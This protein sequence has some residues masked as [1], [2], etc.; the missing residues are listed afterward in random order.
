MKLWRTSEDNFK[1]DL[2]EL[3]FEDVLM[4]T[5]MNLLQPL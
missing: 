4:A 2:T 3:R 1:M 5:I